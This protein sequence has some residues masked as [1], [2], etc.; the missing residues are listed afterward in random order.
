[1]TTQQSE[2]ITRLVA[3]LPELTICDIAALIRKDWGAKVNYAAKPYLEAM[4]E[5]D[6]VDGN[7][8]ADSGKTIIIYFLSNAS[9][10]RGETAKMI[11]A[12][13][14]RRCGIK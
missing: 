14:K 4:Y 6:S 3:R 7:Y 9:T 10:Y 2:I 5:L 11:K 8:G 13:L 1:M 12:E